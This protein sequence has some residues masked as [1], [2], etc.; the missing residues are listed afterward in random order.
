T[1]LDGRGKRMGVAADLGAWAQDGI[2]PV[3]GLAIVKDRLMVADVRDRSAIGAKGKDV[4]LG[5]GA[6]GLADFFLAAFRAAIKPLLPTIYATSAADT[7]ADL[8]K[9][10]TGCEGAV[11]PAMAARVREV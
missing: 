4:T 9:S 10:M 7:Y 1:A 8:Q 2:K 3:D 11:W 6:S 5:S